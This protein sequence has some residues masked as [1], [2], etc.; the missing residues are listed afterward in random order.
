MAW[1]TL[2][3][4]KTLASASRRGSGTL[5]TPTRASMRTDAGGFVHAGEDGEQRC[6]ARHGQADDCGLHVDVTA[7]SGTSTRVEDVLQDALAQFRG[8]LRERDA[9]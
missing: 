9:A 6:L 3:G 8:A 7:Q 5:V 2:G 1:V 4:S